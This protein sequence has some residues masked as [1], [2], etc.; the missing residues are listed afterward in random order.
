MRGDGHR[1]LRAAI[2]GCVELVADEVSA[3]PT[4]TPC[5][6]SGRLQQTLADSAAIEC[7]S[8]GSRTVADDLS[9]AA[10]RNEQ[11]SLAP[12]ARWWSLLVHVFDTA[13][14]TV[15]NLY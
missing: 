12:P 6:E 10:S 7:L 1:C 13:R 2:D 11:T 15:S 5:I 8:A 3:D 4:H 14:T 9:A